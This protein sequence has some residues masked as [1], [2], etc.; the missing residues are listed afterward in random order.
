MQ[1][2]QY[3][4]LKAYIIY[5]IISYWQLRSAC[6]SSPNNSIQLFKPFSSSSHSLKKEKLISQVSLIMRL[7][8]CIV[9]HQL[10]MGTLPMKS[11][12]GLMVVFS[13]CWL[14]IGCLLKVFLIS[15]SIFK[16][17]SILWAINVLFMGSISMLVLVFNQ[18]RSY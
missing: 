11:I 5:K 4:V 2:H 13:N 14:M 17:G 16:V 8:Y 10:K 7:L 12:E 6:L 3:R 18:L 1:W 15:I 9:T